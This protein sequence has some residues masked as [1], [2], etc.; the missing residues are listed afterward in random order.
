[1]CRTCAG[2]YVYRGRRYENNIKKTSVY[3]PANGDLY[4]FTHRKQKNDKGYI[5]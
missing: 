1:M 5:T 4:C 2:F 3:H